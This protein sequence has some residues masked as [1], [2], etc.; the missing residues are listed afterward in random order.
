MVTKKFDVSICRDKNHPTIKKYVDATRIKHEH[1]KKKYFYLIDIK[2][3]LAP[4]ENSSK[5]RLKI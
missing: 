4:R 5:G 2:A 3:E 1:Q